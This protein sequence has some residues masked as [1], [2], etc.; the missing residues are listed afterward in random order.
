M[1]TDPHKPPVPANEL[2]RLEALSDLDLDYTNLNGN[3]SDLTKLAAKVA[4]TEIS[5]INL[6][7]LHTQWTIANYGMDIDQYPRDE[8]ICQY[9][10]MQDTPFEIRDLEQDNR[11]KNKTYVTD[12][13]SLRY[14]YGVP[15]QLEGGQSIGSLCMM[16]TRVKDI[17]PEKI[18]LLK[19]IADEIVNRLKT[20]KAIESLKS[21]L[22]EAQES[23]RRVAH[24]IR[25]PI[26]GIIGLARII[27]EQ[28]DENTLDEV[29]E[30]ITLI[31][32]SGHSI[33][34]LANEILSADTPKRSVKLGNNEYNQLVLKEK[35][36]KL[37]TPQAVNKKINFSIEVN[38]ETSLMPFSKNKLLQIVGNLI[39]NSMKFTPV[40]GRITVKLSIRKGE[41]E[42]HLHMVVEDTGVG[43]DNAKIDEI[44]DGKC[45]T[46]NGTS[47]EQGYGFGLALVK[48]LVDGLNGHMYIASRV[49]SG[50]TFEIVLPQAKGT[51]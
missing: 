8:T 35:L 11:F 3:F 37:Y 12:D 25:G 38:H 48:H 44:L 15:L 45:K 28:G 17:T 30:F 9:T 33:L 23:Q 4:G 42:N 29:L 26:G 2:E 51:E 36:E 21:S 7:D 31:Q 18:E 47:G 40:G 1:N 16:D 46:T 39:S 22:H 14:Y 34:E 10:I 13:P 50:T 24:D 32:K 41:A 5:L 43:M 19:I 49:G 6:L 20:M 27:S